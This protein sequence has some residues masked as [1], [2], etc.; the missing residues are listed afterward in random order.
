MPTSEGQ[1]SA[2]STPIEA[3]NGVLDVAEFF[4]RDQIGKYFHAAMLAQALVL[5]LHNPKITL[6]YVL[7]LLR[8]NLLRKRMLFFRDVYLVDGIS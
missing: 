7:L 1:I 8:L 5:R 2:G 4:E 3:R 6:G